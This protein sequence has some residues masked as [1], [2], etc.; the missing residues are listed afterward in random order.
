[1]FVCLITHLGKLRIYIYFDNML[2]VFEEI[3][4]VGY[5]VWKYMVK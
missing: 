4:V 1:M 2:S 3:D 5:I